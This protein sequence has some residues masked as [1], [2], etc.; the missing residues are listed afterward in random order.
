LSTGTS[1]DR[2]SRKSNRSQGEDPFLREE[3]REISLRSSRVADFYK[4]SIDER[5]KIVK[6]FSG[7]TDE[8]VETLKNSGG[9]K[10]EDADRMI[11]NAVG[12]FSLP[13]GIAVNFTINDKDYLIPMAIEEPSVVAGA[14][15]AARI[16]REGG[17]FHAS[18]TEPIMIAQVQLVDV[19]DPFRAKAEILSRKEEI[20]KIANEQD[21]VLLGL[22][23]GAKDIE[24]RVL[25]TE[26]G[27]MVI[28]HLLVDTKDA[29]G[30]NVINTM[31]EA[32]G[33]KIREIAGTG[34]IYLRIISNLAVRRLSRAWAMFPSKDLGGEDVVDGI[35]YAHA[36]ALAD[37]YR[38]AT[39]NKGVMNGIAAVVQATGNDTRAIEAGAHSFATIGGRY[40][41]LTYWEKNADGD[42]VGS[43]EVPVAVGIVGGATRH[44]QAKI[45]LKILG[46]KSSKELGEVLAAVGLAQN[47]AALRA[48]ATVGIQKGH[49][50]L[51]ARNIAAMAGA[52]GDLIDKVA[53]I[54]VREKKIRVD[55]AR[56]VLEKLAEKK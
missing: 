25:D 46:I 40:S 48:L 28:V 42:L 35:L 31:A 7:L 36:F 33:P 44:P 5:L 1:L 9:L 16:A 39:H 4:M 26:M 18:S 8:E 34:T 56:E 13:V 38:C 30:A 12:A 29:M 41:P 54:I 22:G 51:H 37:P 6:E 19:Q 15:N 55:R 3:Q 47:L 20:L 10:L 43:I 21:P 24:A 14:S 49:M 11:E 45:N 17:G 23:G 2:R 50:S 52:K 32:T 53:E 27:P